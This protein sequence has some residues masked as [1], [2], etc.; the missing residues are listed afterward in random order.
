MDRM[1]NIKHF[2]II[3]LMFYVLCS[4]PTSSPV[5]AGRLDTLHVVLSGQGYRP[6]EPKGLH[7]GFSGLPLIAVKGG[8][9]YM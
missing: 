5:P 1:E 3:F 7:T 9:S 2:F 6:S 4:I 8:L